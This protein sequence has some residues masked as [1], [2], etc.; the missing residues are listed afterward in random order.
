MTIDVTSPDFIADPYAVYRRLNESSPITQVGPADYLVTQP[1]LIL[2][3]FQDSETFTSI[4]NLEGHFPVC[5]EAREI[6]DK[7][8]FY[9]GALFNE[10]PPLHSA[11]RK[12]FIRPFTPEAVRGLE[13]KIS[14]IA[15]A[16]CAPI[17][18]RQ[19]FDVM[20]ELAFPLPIQIISDMIGIP[21]EDR[22][23][24]KGWNDL[25][26]ALQVAPLPPEAQ[27]GAA[28]TVGAYEEYVRALIEDIGRDRRPSLILEMLDAIGS[29]GA[30]HNVDDIIVAIRVMIAAGHE[31]TSG[32]IGN[33][34][35]RL[36]ETGRWAQTADDPEVIADVVEETLAADPSVQ[37][38]P[39]SPTR[40]VEIGGL[41]L[42][43][44]ARL[45]LAIGAYSALAQD[46]SGKA[47][48]VV[49]ENK[50]IG[51]GH[52]IHRCIGSHLARAEA[53][54]ALRA[55]LA[56]V[57]APPSFNNAVPP[58]RLPGGFVFRS[59]SSLSIIW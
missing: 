24:V 46:D 56:A 19:S 22:Q 26:L 17:A 6:L 20:Q 48:A 58:Q 15:T 2:D 7:T 57:P 38:A 50:H 27:I 4:H 43:E 16:L 21:E 18:A 37:S 41:T 5:D 45:H 36:I 23:K 52:G 51:F 25:W 32:L 53:S 8:L 28:Q 31:T 11:F 33:A 49:R 12:T 40:E 9:R 14:E 55:L 34:A 39:R 13:A 1:D 54:I 42:S 59:Y 30:V 35:A 44:G 3:I 29:D 10:G 47:S